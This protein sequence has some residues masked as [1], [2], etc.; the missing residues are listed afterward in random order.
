MILHYAKLCALAGG[1]DAF[2]LSSELVGLTTLRSS[3]NSYPFVSA[4]QTLAAEVKAIL[5]TAKISYGAD[6]SE[7]FGHHAND[8]TGD[9]FFH[10]DP[11]WASPSIDFIGIDNYLPLTDWRD[12]T[13]HVDYLAGTHSIYDQNYLQSRISSGE[14]FDWYYASQTDRDA[15]VRTPIT[16]GTYLKPWVFRPKDIKSWWSNSHFNRPAGIE[17]ATPTAWVPQSKPIW[18]TETGCPAIDK[19]SNAPNTF[20]D[21]KSAESALPYY[22]GGQQD[23]QIQNA[24]V[25]TVQNFWS[26]ST[27]NPVSS[28]YSAKMVEPSRIF[29]WSWDA[30]PFPAFPSRSDVWSDADN[31]ARGHWLNGRL[32]AVDLGDLIVAIAARFA[33][34]DVDVNDVEGQVDGFVIDRPLSARDALEGLL[35]SFALDAIESDGRLVFKARCNADQLALSL[36]DLVEESVSQPILVQSRAQ[37]TELAS[38]IR[39][40]YID[41]N[42]DYRAGAVAQN[43]VGTGSSRELSFSVPAVLGQAL[44]QARADVA[45]AE[46]WAAR[47]T[48][49]FNLSPK[50]SNVEVGDVI[51]MAGL[52]WRVKSIADSTYRKI[53]ALSYD[54]NVYDAPPANV[55]ATA[56]SSPNVYG[57]PDYAVLD[58]ARAATIPA[59]WLGAH[60]APWP[61]ALALYKKT[62]AS[63]FTFNRLLSQQATMAAT[64]TNLPKGKLD[65]LDFGTSLRVKMRNGA[66]A[67][68]SQDELLSGLNLCAVGSAATGFEI[69]QFKTVSLIAADTYELKGL[70]RGLYG[71]QAEMLTLRTA[72]QDFVLLN[73]AVVQPDISATEA[74]LTTTW[75]LGP[76]SLDHGHPSFVEFDIVGQLK[77]LRPLAPV[78]L[79]SVT[80]SGDVQ[81]S[82]IRATR[83]DGDSWDLNDVPLG[84]SSELYKLDI[85]NGA[86]VLRSV[87]VATPNYIYLAAN[88]AADFGSTPLNFT[89]RVAQI[90]ATYGAGTS[91]ERIINV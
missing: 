36:D 62:G 89:A 67:S 86:S 74:G 3:A 28:F 65:L 35:Q 75:R 73:D 29:Y 80:I 23:A 46:N 31:Y 79:S 2:I 83:I 48:A 53:E 90:S 69:I 84:E 15:Q 38:T 91:V 26:T 81:I 14:Y 63:S 60:A 82:W 76:G 21:A 61:S 20:Y 64:L 43:K 5:P 59:A 16:D 24:F 12:G 44:A 8:G 49:L 39:L 57:Q 54:I 52:R 32:A 9:F 47:E 34:V 27:L 22:S 6:W 78:R 1:V 88:I 11:L 77:S 19:G 17:A 40:G 58:L 42:L 71:S 25:K 10:L 87:T 55:R 68:I 4:L 41:A 13:S 33:F 30:R 45:M 70:L 66:L 50:F 85:L 18:F 37:E 56:F 7:Y 51:Q 72:P